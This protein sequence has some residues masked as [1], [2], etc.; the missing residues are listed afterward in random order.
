MK[1]KVVSDGRR[2]SMVDED[3]GFRFPLQSLSFSIGVDTPAI[4]TVSMFSD[5]LPGFSLELSG[6][7]AIDATAEKGSETR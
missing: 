2:C 3:T 7:V 1:I 4:L 5:R 6:E